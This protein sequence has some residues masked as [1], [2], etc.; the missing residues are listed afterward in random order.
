MNCNGKHYK[1]GSNSYPV[2][3]E[4]ETSSEVWSE[5]SSE[6]WSESEW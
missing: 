2:K 6:V 4:V 3:Y 5:S 1:C